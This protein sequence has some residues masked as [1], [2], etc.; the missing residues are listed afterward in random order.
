M[1]SVDHD[2]FHDLDRGTPRLVLWS[3][4]SLPAI[5]SLQF[6]LAGQALFGGASWGLHGAVG[7]L[8]ALPVLLLVGSSLAVTRLRGF[9]WSAGLTGLLYLVQVALGLGGPELLAFHPFNAALLLTSALVLAA[10]L[11]RR[12]ARHR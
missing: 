10:K 12:R 4:R 8:A 7:G 6:L 2:T 5:L 3:A 11:E 1:T 9:A